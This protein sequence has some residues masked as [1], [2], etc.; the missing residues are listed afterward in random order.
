MM[1][2]GRKI[3][4]GVALHCLS[5]GANPVRRRANRPYGQRCATANGPIAA[6]HDG[7][8]RKPIV[9]APGPRRLFCLGALLA[10]G[11]LAMGAPFSGLQAQSVSGAGESAGHRHEAHPSKGEGQAGTERG[12]R[13]PAGQAPGRPAH[14]DGARVGGTHGDPAR[15]A[16]APG[17]PAHGRHGGGKDRI[18]ASG[19]ACTEPSLACA[20]SATPVFAPDG[21]LWLA[22]YA[23]GH[24][25][26][27]RSA[28]KGATFDAPVQVTP[29]PAR[30]DLGADSRPQIAIGA[31]GRVTVAYAILRDDRYNGQVLVARSSDGGRH[32]SDPVPIAP[33]TASQRFQVLGLDPDGHVFAAWQD[34]RDDIPGHTSKAPGHADAALVFAW[35][36]AKGAAPARVAA[37]TTCECCR[38]GLAFAGPGRPVVAF[39][40][41]Y[42]GNIRDHAVVAFQDRDA[43]GPLARI[44][45]DMWALEGCPHQGPALAVSAAGTIHA[46]WFSGGG[47]RMGLFAARRVAGGGFSDPMPVGDPG[48]QTSRAELL[49]RG[50]DVW[51]AWKSFDGERMEIRLMRS[52][53]DGATW[54]PPRTVAATEDESDPPLLIGDARTVWLSWLTKR[55]GYRLIALD[56]DS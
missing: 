10:A 27:A 4:I 53:D 32:F 37:G 56:P 20:T 41:I 45:E 43:P 24:L 44:S 22:W 9:P 54:G 51:L 7:E 3:D 28:D 33:G 19:R 52:R 55:E 31:D 17:G 25:S 49:A 39:R 42:P 29:R 26:V 50:T 16:P 13:Q 2:A 21:A 1:P 40:N 34:R 38:L 14:G 11:L 18:A 48:R 15:N 6:R 35:L 23:S 5:A 12:D 30:L 47:T 36:D 8:T 46:A